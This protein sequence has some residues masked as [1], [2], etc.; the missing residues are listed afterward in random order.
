MCREL[1]EDFGG[2]K[3]AAGLSLREENLPLFKEVFQTAVSDKV[4][5]EDLVPRL[6]LEGSVQLSI[7]REK[8]FL[9]DF[10]LLPPFGMGNPNPLLDTSPV[11]IIEQRLIGEKHVKLRVHQDGRVWEAM[12]FNMAPLPDAE[13]LEAAL[14]FALDTNNYQGRESLQL[15]VVDLKVIS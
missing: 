4:T 1:L 13:F 6:W 9:S 7:L 12:G 2:H 8:S 5:T 11:K 15:R 10:Y 3:E 14:A